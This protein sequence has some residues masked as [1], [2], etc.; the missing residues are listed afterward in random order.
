MV[1][2][3]DERDQSIPVI[4]PT[5]RA[6]IEARYR[7]DVVAAIEACNP[8]LETLGARSVTTMPRFA[9]FR[10]SGACRRST[11]AVKPLSASKIR[12]RRAGAT[13]CVKR[14][15]ASDSPCDG[16]PR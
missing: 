6:L 16:R 9:R 15:R 5:S 12:K 10:A 13:V 2:E 11:G 4:G 8:T 3:K 1:V 14:S 7:A